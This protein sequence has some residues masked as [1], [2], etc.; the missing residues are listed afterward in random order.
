[1]KDGINFNARIPYSILKQCQVR[2]HLN[3]MV[4]PLLSITNPKNFVLCIQEICLFLCVIRGSVPL[5]FL[6][7]N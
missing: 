3:N 2:Y 7:K 5:V 4:V 1:V 6:V